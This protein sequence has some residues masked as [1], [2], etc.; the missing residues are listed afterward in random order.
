VRIGLVSDCYHPTKNGVTGMVDLLRSGLVARGHEVVLLAPRSPERWTRSGPLGGA[1]GHV[2]DAGQEPDVA[3]RSLALLPSIQ[4]RLAP[5]T[6]RRVGR[7]LDGFRP[8]LVHT[9]T[10]GPLGIAARRAATTRAIPT[11]HTLHTFYEHYLHYLVP[12][13]LHGAAT[14]RLLRAVMSRALRDHDHIVAPSVRALAEA[15]SLAPGVAST[16]VPNG[17][18]LTPNADEPQVMTQLRQRL[19]LGSHDRLLLSVG[20]LAPEKRSEQLFDALRPHLVDASDLKVVFVGGGPLL[21]RLRA[22]AVTSGVADRIVLPGYLPHEQVLALYRLASVYLTASLS[23]NHPLTL[24]EAAA[25]GLPL[26]ARRDGFDAGP[27]IDGHNGI[28]A[29]DDRALAAAAIDLTRE[30]L[31]RS[32]YGAAARSMVQ[33]NTDGVHLDRMERLYREVIAHHQADRQPVPTHRG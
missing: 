32:R 19:G 15:A 9:H 7:M 28:L 10:E 29:D 14:D 27:V 11:V 23:E 18:S 26:V 12:A 4:L 5:T 16:L 8:D 1:T 33:A 22:R 24:L 13:R 2:H 6:A 31:R 3:A 25:A 21:R 17:V 30:P 20:R